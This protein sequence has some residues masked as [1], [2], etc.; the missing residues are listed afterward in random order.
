M[1]TESTWEQ[2]SRVVLLSEGFSSKIYVRLVKKVSKI[3]AIQ[4][5]G[6]NYKLHNPLYSQFLRITTFA[7]DPQH[8]HFPIILTCDIP[9]IEEFAQQ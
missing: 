2:S 4:G 1:I 7:G 9:K 3:L 8:L 5:S 6:F